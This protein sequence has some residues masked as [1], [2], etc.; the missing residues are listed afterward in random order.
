MSDLDS[1]LDPRRWRALFVI[2]LAQLMVVLDASI[3][4]I[5]LP[6]AAVDLHISPQNYQWTVT[7]YLLTFGGFLLLGGRIADFVG[8]RKVFMFGLSGF[9][10]HRNQS[11][12]H[13]C[14]AARA[15]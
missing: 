14:V 8:R 6:K 5:A 9:A 4:N 7:A 11:P 3:V 2:A 15:V 10:E 13:H 1:N 12:R